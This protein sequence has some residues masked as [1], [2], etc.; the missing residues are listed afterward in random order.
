METIIKIR[1]I[2]LDNS[3]LGNFRQISASK[4]AHPSSSRWSGAY[5]HFSHG[6]IL[7]AG[8]NLSVSQPKM[9]PRMKRE[10]KRII[11]VSGNIASMTNASSPLVA[12]IPP[13]IAPKEIRPRT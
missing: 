3:I 1:R 4:Y 12:I 6:F 9:I 13:T 7:R 5:L 10:K 2:I 11:A 8:T